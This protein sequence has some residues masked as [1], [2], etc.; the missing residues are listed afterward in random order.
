MSIDCLRVSVTDRCNLR[1][2]YCHPLP[3]CGI[4]K[5][6]LTGGEP[7]LKRSIIRLVSELAIITEKANYTKSNS[8]KEEFSM[9]KIGG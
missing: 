7:L 1:C 8:L 4:T 3:E 5:V 9:C 2:I 6:R